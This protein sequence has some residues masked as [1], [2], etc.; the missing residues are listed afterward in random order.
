MLAIYNYIHSEYAML[1][2]SLQKNW[3]GERGRTLP[4]FFFFNMR[5]I[6]D[7][8]QTQIPAVERLLP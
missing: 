7:V 2:S 4:A 6:N 3:L 5:D 8:R 1:I